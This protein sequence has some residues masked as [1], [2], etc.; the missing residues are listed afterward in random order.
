VRERGRGALVGRRGG[1]GPEGFWAVAGKKR[2][3]GGPWGKEGGW[4]GPRGGFGFVCFFCF[5]SFLSFSTH[6]NQ[7]PTKI[8][9]TLI[10]LFYFIYKNNQLIFLF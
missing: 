4:A 5:F 6:N 3:K 2:E 8:K 7:K 9:A 1:V 10:H